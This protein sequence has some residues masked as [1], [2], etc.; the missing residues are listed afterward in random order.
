VGWRGRR[1]KKKKEREKAVGN[2]KGGGTNWVLSNRNRPIRK[3]RQD[4]TTE[5]CDAHAKIPPRRNAFLSGGQAGGKVKNKIF[6][7]QDSGCV[8]FNHRCYV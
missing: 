2:R 5:R 8:C 7:F 6:F 1:R 3:R 4:V